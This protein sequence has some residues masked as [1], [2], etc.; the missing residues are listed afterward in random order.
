MFLA[1]SASELLQQLSLD[2]E[3]PDDNQPHR[4]SITLF[5]P[6]LYNAS[7]PAEA[8]TRFKRRDASNLV[9]VVE[10]L[11]A[12][13]LGIDDACFVEV[14]VRKK[15]GPTENR[16]GL[17]IIIERLTD[18]AGG[19]AADR[20]GAVGRPGSAERNGAGDVG[21]SQLPPQR[22]IP[23]VKRSKPRKAGDC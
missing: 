10:D 16:E 2:A 20:V 5:F 3:Q 15:D 9:K 12:R 8:K 19:A 1:R 23:T 14:V 4:L 6:A 13:S 11:V 18:E 22:V 21:P 17:D 7:W